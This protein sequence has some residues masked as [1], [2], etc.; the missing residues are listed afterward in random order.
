[1]AESATRQTEAAEKKD[2]ANELPDWQREEL[3]A[4]L[5]EHRANPDEGDSWE[6]V[7]EQL[8]KEL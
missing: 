8:R 4:R 3:E 6:Q 1:M 2:L 5:A 7:R